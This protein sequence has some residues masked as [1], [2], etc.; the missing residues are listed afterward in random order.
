MY[1]LALGEVGYREGRDK[2]G[3]WNNK[4][5]YSPAVPGL[6]WSQNQ[7]WCDT[8]VCWVFQKAG[9]RKLLPVVS[10]SCDISAAAWKRQGRW[11]EYPAIMAQVF[12]GTP[13]DL[14]HTGLVYKYDKD[15]IWTIEGNTN[16]NGSRQGD[17]VYKLKRRRRDNHVV[18]YGYPKFTEGIVSADPRYGGKNE[19]TVADTVKGKP[20][21]K[22]APKKKKKKKAPKQYLDAKLFPPKGSYKG[23]HI[24][25]LGKRLVAH[26]FAKHYNVGPGP[27][28]GAA[29]RANVKDFQLAQGWRGNDADGYPGPETL[30]RLAADPKASKPAPAKPKPK[31]EPAPRPSGLRVDGVDLSHHQTTYGI[32]QFEQAKEA[33]VKFIYH[34]ATQRASWKDS[35][36]LERRL[37]AEKVGIRFGAYH[38]AETSPVREQAEF[39]LK[40]ARPKPGDMLPMLDLEDDKINRS[41]FSAMSVRNRTLWVKTWVDIVT[42][43]IG[44]KP[45]I[46][47]PFDLNDNFG[48]KLWTARYNPNNAEPPIPKPWDKY[49][50]RQFSNG[51][52][53][54][55]SSVAGFGAVDLNTLPAGVSVKDLLI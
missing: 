55:P 29:D 24:T 53:G 32:R 48:C 47:T 22:P 43:E 18:G 34:K 30:R 4:Q 35:E 19:A 50:I 21:P 13:S 25:W 9:L 52:I 23:A 37:L 6:E 27:N 31:P 38:F 11:S 1:E 16:T 26:G 42:D 54:K 15:Y 10:A 7:P 14:N 51:E 44:K 41:F 28:W 49:T 17:G 46:Y 36:Y 3:N 45:I 33:G 5:K 2:N 20:D 8:F 40:V 12:Y 39:F